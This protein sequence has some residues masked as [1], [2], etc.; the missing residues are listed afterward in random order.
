[1][2]NQITVFKAKKIITMDHNNPEATHVAVR[3]GVILAVGDRHCADGWGDIVNNDTYKDKVILPGLIEAHAHV[4][5]GGVWANIYCGHYDRTDPE[6]NIVKGLPTKEALIEK[7]RQAPGNGPIVGWGFDPNFLD[8]PRLSKLELNE[9]STDRPVIVVHSNFHLATVNTLALDKSGITAGLNIEGI[10]KGPDGQPNGELQEF[11]AMEP[12]LSIG[13]ITIGELSTKPS[14]VRNYATMARN[15]G[16]TTIADLLSDLD[17]PEVEMLQKVT[18]DENF[19][20]R[21]VPIMNAMRGDPELEAKRATDLK[22]KSTDKLRLGTAKLFTDGAI[23]GFTAKLNEPGY[24]DGP[25]NGIYNMEDTH[26]RK[27]VLELHKAGVKMHIHTN[28]DQASDY[29][30]DVLEDAIRAYPDADHRHTLE[31]VQLADRMDFIRMNKLGIC[32]NLFANHLHY[33]GDVHWK[34]TL[35]PDRANRMDACRDATEVFTNNFAIHSD[36][37]VT[38]LAPLVTA[39]CAINRITEKGRTL[40]STQQ[41]SLQQ[42]LYCITLGA[43]YILKLEKEIGS[44]E[45]GKKADLCII[46]SDP[47][48]LKP[49]NLRDIKVIDTVFSGVPT[50]SLKPIHSM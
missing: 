2:S 27:A 7:L 15:V 8:S 5:A 44:I 39:W 13:G 14:A 47:F 25:D 22:P 24:Y 4:S 43:A 50:S 6:G 32:V 28:G 17:P 1:M 21:Y 40:G 48:N 9:V 26:F 30:T 31:H 42:A 38:P 3:D 19:P 35:G 29:A 37:P 36:A 10:V 49:Q 46:D 18:S 23:Q 20:V 45:T 12:A 11:A 33:F 16:V 34:T 41:I